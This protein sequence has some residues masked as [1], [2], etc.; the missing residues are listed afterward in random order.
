MT[1][2]EL[3]AR[4]AE[5]ENEMRLLQIQLIDTKIELKGIKRKFTAKKHKKIHITDHAMIRYL[6]RMYGLDVEAMRK[7]I[8]SPK[9]RLGAYFTEAGNHEINEEVY[10]VVRHNKVITVIRN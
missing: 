10:A 5:I 3:E 7:E 8:L 2:D 1:I 4:A 9:V 6:E